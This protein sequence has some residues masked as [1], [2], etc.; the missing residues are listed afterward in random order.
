[1]PGLWCVGV[2]V[3]PGWLQGT[4]VGEPRH[5]GV[6]SLPWSRLHGTVVMVNIELFLGMRLVQGRM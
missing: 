1:M 3:T 2:V 4:S 5:D 6:A